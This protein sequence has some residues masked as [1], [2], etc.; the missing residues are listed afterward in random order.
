MLDSELLVPRE[1]PFV[2]PSSEGLPHDGI[3]NVY[4]V[5][6]AHLPDFPED[7]EALDDSRF[8]EAVVKD[9]V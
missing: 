6:A 2:D 9:T 1:H 4:T 3:D 7:R 5:L 8:A